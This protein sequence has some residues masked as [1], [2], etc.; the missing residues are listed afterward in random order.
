MVW[1]GYEH[2]LIHTLQRGTRVLNVTQIVLRINSESAWNLVLT[3][4]SRTKGLFLC[5]CYVKF[6]RHYPG[7]L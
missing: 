6:Q 2:Y 3:S 7:R 1:I 5:S 4:L